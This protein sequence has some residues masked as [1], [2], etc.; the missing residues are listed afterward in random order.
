[1]HRAVKVAA[2]GDRHH[3]RGWLALVAISLIVISSGSSAT[4]FGSSSGN[5]AAEKVRATE[6]SHVGAT[7]SCTDPQR[8][9]TV[10]GAP[11][12]NDVPL[13]AAVTL[14]PNDGALSISFSFR[15]RLVY[16]PAGV[17]LAWRVFVYTNRQHATSADADLTFTVEDRGAGWEPTG[18]TIVVASGSS[19]RQVD[20]NVAI[21]SAGN[22]LSVLYPRGFGDL[23]TPF[24]WYANQWAVRS[25]MPTDNPKSPDY[26]INGSVSTDCPAVLDASGLPSPERLLRAGS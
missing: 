24:Y 26:S 23:S 19:S 21:N 16:A 14:S 12:L 5:G 6:H 15:H 10:E 20:G 4:A 17:L 18:W 1:L 22:E 25:F 13:L 7:F 2:H 8:N 9:A 3:H 11:Q